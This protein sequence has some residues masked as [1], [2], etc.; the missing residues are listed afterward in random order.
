MKKGDFVKPKLSPTTSDSIYMVIEYVTSSLDEEEDTVHVQLKNGSHDWF[1]VSELTMVPASDLPTPAAYSWEEIIKE[2]LKG[3]T[4][5]KN[6]PIPAPKASR[7]RKWKHVLSRLDVGDSFAVPCGR[8]G[9]DRNRL[10]SSMNF[11]AKA[12]G[13]KI[14][15]RRTD[16][17]NLRIWRIQ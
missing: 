11:G 12:A 3:I 9:A 7:Q 4:I 15:T 5:E 13:I 6:I 17:G 8:T 1:R 10:G 14:A 2:E 16:D